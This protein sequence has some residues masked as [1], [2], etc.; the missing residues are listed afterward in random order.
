MLSNADIDALRA[1]TPGITEPDGQVRTRLHFNHAGASL[2]DRSVSEAIAAHYQQELQCGAM[3]AGVQAASAIAAG[4][5]LVAKLLGANC[6]EIAFASSGSMAHG[7][8]FA[9]LPKLRTGD[10]IL[11]GRQEW[12]G[13][14]ASYRQAAQRAGASVEVIPC[15]AD[16]SV[17]A[18]AL[19]NL[20]DARV[21][22]VSLTWL[23]ANGGLI[24]DA[25][26]IG[27][28][29]RAANI[30]YFIDAGQALGQLPID[31]QTLQCDVLKSAGRKHLRGPRGTAILYVRKTFLTTLEPAF[32]S[33]LAATDLETCTLNEAPTL[34]TDAR[35]FECG[36]TSGALTLGLCA[37]LD[38]ALTIDAQ[39]SFT[40]IQMLAN[41]LRT[42]LRS[43]PS[44]SL[45]DL[46]TSYL[47]GLVSFSVGKLPA[48][49]VQA[50]LA[51]QD[52]TIG[53]NGAS[54][55]PLDMLARGLDG[56]VRASVS[57][58]HTPSEIEQLT[59]AV[60]RISRVA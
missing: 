25:A 60:A 3:E 4:R 47:S 35:L 26:A 53:A 52:I 27:R 30:P 12:G 18:A 50:L 36:E 31:V 56:V 48:P 29:T 24:N 51:Q 21:R 54:Y 38:L 1:R 2:P 10:R 32:L 8:A 41:A 9:A 42:Q 33:T 6:E 49:Q 5:T 55:T 59:Q 17:D 19:A 34:R 43:I 40:R 16:G 14:L 57:Y 39:A 44:V 28:V 20:I 23:P 7:L 22:L 46:G 37:A 11:V 13:N 45:H 58:L 15:C